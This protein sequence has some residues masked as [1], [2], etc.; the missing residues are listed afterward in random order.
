MTTEVS[1]KIKETNVLMTLF[2]VAL[3]T[4]LWEE[5][6]WFVKVLANMAVPV[7]FCISSYLYFQKWSPTWKNYQ[8]KFFSRIKSLY[9][10]FLFYNALYLP[11]IF[12]KTH[13]L[14]MPDTRMLS[15]LSTDMITGL[16]LGFP[17]PPNTVLW[18]VRDL[19]LFVLMAPA[20]ALMARHIKYLA[21]PLTI[22]FLL[23][24]HYFN[25]YLVF[26]WLPCFLFGALM[27][28]HEAK[29][30]AVVHRDVA[31]HR[32][33][34]I[35]SGLLFLLF[36][37]LLLRNE[38]TYYSPWYYYYRMT[39]PVV[40]LFCHHCFDRLMSKKIV[41]ALAPYTFPLFCMHV[42]FVNFSVMSFSRF[43]PTA[44]YL[45]IQLLSFTTAVSVVI[46]LCKLLS[47]TK[48]IWPVMTG[49]RNHKNKR[50]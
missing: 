13:L 20:I 9:V 5:R 8:S 31:R 4:M 21:L 34:V 50:I 10:P 45:L 17:I 47:H 37:T 40:Y 42:V 38:N 33:T 1:R 26:Y 7:F 39:V 48:H 25:Y 28:F 6:M 24:P 18:Y 36:F 30:L 43:I 15:P 32:A 16:F 3:H 11:Y 35:I 29:I 49:F 44:H 22:L 23:L 27:A 12:L 14:H 19:L 46:F 2:V 41:D